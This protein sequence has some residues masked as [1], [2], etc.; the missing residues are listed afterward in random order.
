MVELVYTALDVLV[1]AL[2][3]WVAFYVIYRLLHEDR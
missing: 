1:G 3:A 2:I